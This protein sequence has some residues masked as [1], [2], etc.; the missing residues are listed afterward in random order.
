MKN[1]TYYEAEK[2]LKQG[3]SDLDIFTIDLE[4]LTTAKE[5]SKNLISQNLP[6]IT[7]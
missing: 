2:N 3:G 1:F 6:Q 4:S 7:G 5:L